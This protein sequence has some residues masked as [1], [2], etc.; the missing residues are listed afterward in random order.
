[1]NAA[2]RSSTLAVSLR[3]RHVCDSVEELLEGATD[4]VPFAASDSKSGSHFER[5]QL[6]G[7][8]HIVKY[9]HVDDDFTMRVFGDLG[10]R[11]LL[12]W[13]SGL[14]DIAPDLIEHGTVGVARGVGRN[15]WGAAILMRDLS[16]AMVPEG[17]ESVP[18]EHHLRF[19]DH[20][21][22]MSARTWDWHDDIGLMPYQTRWQAFGNGMMES[23]RELGFPTIVPEIAAQGWERFVDVAP[24]SVVALISELRAD[25][26]PLIDALKTTP[27]TFLHGD[28]KFGNLGALADG[29]TALIDWSY[30]GEGPIAHDLAWYLALNAARLPMSKEDTI[31]VLRAA[32][33][34][35]GIDVG[36]WWPRQVALCL[37]GALVQFGWEK[38]L[39]GHEELAWWSERALEAARLL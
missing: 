34:R 32:L 28:W 23:E 3:Q 11:P 8:P 12:V 27:S 17:D 26:T 20:L 33:V 21:A 15:G 39:G 9:V 36:D 38:A 37:L 19:I 30:P 24:P 6:N 16:D 13:E 29:R 31:E 25:A 5:L 1:M 7:R 4:R 35:H 22:G 18:M 14:M 2:A 10:P